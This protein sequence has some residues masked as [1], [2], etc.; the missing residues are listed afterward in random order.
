[1]KIQSLPRTGPITHRHAD[2]T[3]RMRAFPTFIPTPLRD[4][5]AETHRQFA[6]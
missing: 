5:L 1:V 4:G 2:V 6:V 3:A